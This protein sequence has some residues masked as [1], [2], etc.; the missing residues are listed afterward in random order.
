MAFSPIKGIKN[1]F[2][3]LGGKW[4]PKPAFGTGL[5]IAALAGAIGVGITVAVG[6]FPL[7]AAT[8]AGSLLLTGIAAGL[9]AAGTVGD[10]KHFATITKKQKRIIE[11]QEAKIQIKQQ[12]FE[13]LGEPQNSPQAKPLNLDDLLEAPQ[14]GKLRAA[15]NTLT[16]KHGPKPA[17]WAIVATTAE[18]GAVGLGVAVAVCSLPLSATF[19]AA[20]LFTGGSAAALSS[21]KSASNHRH[22]DQIQK[23]EDTE[24]AMEEEN[25]QLEQELLNVIKE[26]KQ[27]FHPAASAPNPA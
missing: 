27:E 26:K 18:A 22:F 9:N 20:S 2:K 12:I 3:A 24:M 4:G 25:L 15:W 17:G 5:A 21:A 10:H 6:A 19:F 1:I 7:T 23:L 11:L 14:K 13:L 16:F 8:F